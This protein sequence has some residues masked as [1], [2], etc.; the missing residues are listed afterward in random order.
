[1]IIS[2]LRRYRWWHYSGKSFDTIFI[3]HLCIFN[4][5]I[6]YLQ[7]IFRYLILT[8]LFLFYF[9]YLAHFHTQNKP[10]SLTWVYKQGYLQFECY[11]PVLKFPLYFAFKGV[12]KGHC[13]SSYP[14]HECYNYDKHGLIYRDVNT[15][16]TTYIIPTCDPESFNGRW[17]CVHGQH[18]SSTEV[19]IRMYILM[20]LRM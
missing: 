17:S 19:E 18:N 9:S 6:S 8:S 7:L 12:D 11:V 4:I 3:Y 16:I 20:W 14:S 13:T 15:N 10:V 5:Y 1:M 2:A